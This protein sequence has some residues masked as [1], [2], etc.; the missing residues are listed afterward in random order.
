MASLRN[1][2]GAEVV[3][4]DGKCHLAL[5]VN[6]T[7]VSAHGSSSCSCARMTHDGVW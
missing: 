7:V 1:G 6:V 2:A 4:H 3:G 5:W